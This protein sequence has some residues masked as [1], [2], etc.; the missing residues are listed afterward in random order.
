MNKQTDVE[1]HFGRSI[2]EWFEGELK[3]AKSSPKFWTEGYKLRITESMLE[4]ME[5]NDISEDK[6]KDEVSFDW[7]DFLSFEEFSLENLAEV[8]MKLGI[9][10]KFNIVEV[11]DSG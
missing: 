9:D 11:P 1:E 7:E 8:S 10:W 3:K 6:I 5:D 4:Y 2:E